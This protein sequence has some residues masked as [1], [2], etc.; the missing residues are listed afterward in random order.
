MLSE[1]PVSFHRLLCGKAASPPS[2]RRVLLEKPLILANLAC[3]TVSC[4]FPGAWSQGAVRAGGRPWSSGTAVGHRGSERA[5]GAAGLV[6]TPAS[7]FSFCATLGKLLS[8]SEPHFFIYEMGRGIASTLKV[9]RQ[10]K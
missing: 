7:P 3:H 10:I 2:G 6:C 8:L 1:T 5:H 9:I 4:L